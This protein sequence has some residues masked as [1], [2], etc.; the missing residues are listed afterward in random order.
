MTT[1]ITERRTM[2]EPPELMQ[3]IEWFEPHFFNWRRFSRIG[4]VTRIAVCL[5]PFVVLAIARD[6]AGFVRMP[7]VP[8]FFFAFALPTQLHVVITTLGE[9]TCMPCIQ[10]V[11]SFI[12]YKNWCRAEIRRI[13]IRRTSETNQRW[14]L[15]IIQ[16]KYG[17]PYEIA[18]PDLVSLDDL[19]YIFYAAKLQ[20]SLSD[21]DPSL[22]LEVTVQIEEQEQRI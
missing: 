8:L 7:W 3:P 16:T 15:M 18:I 5:Y 4:W 9:I 21:W 22:Y 6:F 20:V 19:A 11:P 14:A 10:I 12:G 13:E 2:L 17:K 1:L